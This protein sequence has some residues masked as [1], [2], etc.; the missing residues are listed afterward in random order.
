MLNKR[1]ISTSS[2]ILLF[3][4]MSI[5]GVMLFTHFLDNYVKEI[6]ELFGLLFIVAVAFHISVNFFSFK[7]YPKKKS[8]MVLSSIIVS[9]IAIFIIAQ[10][11][12]QKGDN[13]K[14]LLM[15][16]MLEAP[17]E[18]SIKVL[19]KDFNKAIKKLENNGIKVNREDSIS[20]IAKDNNKSPFEIVNII[21]KD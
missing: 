14:K 5:T 2:T 4:V 8:F 20:K 1:N 7:E 12:M 19:D 17:I 6:H 11:T 15:D 21:N 10:S 16:A 13:P 3:F 9:I 18:H